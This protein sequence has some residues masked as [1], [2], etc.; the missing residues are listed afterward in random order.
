LP[1]RG[2]HYAISEI[3]YCHRK[4]RSYIGGDFGC[5]FFHFSESLQFKESYGIIE[6]AK[7]HE[8]SSIFKKEETM[9]KRLYRTK[10]EKKIAGV[11]A[12]L[13]EYFNVDPVLIRLIMVLLVFAYGIGILAYIVGWIIIPEKP[14]EA[15]LNKG[16]KHE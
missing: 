15:N 13:G 8:L 11:C 4:N 9:A 5:G 6:E 1:P 14:V 16:E 7:H 12:G 2:D 3:F 10:T